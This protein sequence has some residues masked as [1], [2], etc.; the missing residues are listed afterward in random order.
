V[1]PSYVARLAR[2]GTPAEVAGAFVVN[3]NAWG[4]CCARMADALPRSYQLTREDCAFFAHFAGPTTELERI[5]LKVI[6]AG[7]AQGVDPASIARAARLLQAY[8]LLF[9]NSLPR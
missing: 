4:S 7:L 6:D 2:D 3:L 9:W 8:E 1:Y 5:S